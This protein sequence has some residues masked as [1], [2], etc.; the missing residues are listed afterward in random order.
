MMAVYN[1]LR[2]AYLDEVWRRGRDATAQEALHELADEIPT[3]D[4]QAARLI[5]H[6]SKHEKRVIV[7][8]SNL[9]SERCAKSQALRRALNL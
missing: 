8:A 9:S 7:D 5:L 3:G 2:T 6:L 4:R 1:R